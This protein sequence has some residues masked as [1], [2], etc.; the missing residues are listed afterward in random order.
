[1]EQHSDLEL[2]EVDENLDPLSGATGAH[3]LGTGVGAAS[4]GAAGAAIGSLAGPIGA[5]V[6]LVAGAV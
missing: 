2:V 1:M 4:A 3:P 5:A 6:G